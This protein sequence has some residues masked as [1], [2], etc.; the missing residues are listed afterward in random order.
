M[1]GFQKAVEKPGCSMVGCQPIAVEQ[2]AMHFIREDE[3]LEIHVSL[4]P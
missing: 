1:P 4:S 3:L 2:K